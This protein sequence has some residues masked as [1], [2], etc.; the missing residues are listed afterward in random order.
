MER[1]RGDI[2]VEGISFS[3]EP[4]KPV[5]KE[6][7]FEIAEGEML[8][9]IGHSGAGKST[10]A[11]LITRLYDLEEGAIRIDGVNVKKIK[12]SDLRANIAMVSQESYLFIGTI[13]ENISYSSKDATLEEIVAAAK[14]AN[15]H[16]FIMKF[17]DG[18]DTVIGRG[19]R[20]LSG[21]EKQRVSIARAILHNPRVLILDEATSAVDTETEGLI[22]DAI[23]KL[24]KGRTTI[25][26]AHRLSTLRNADK[27]VIL[28]GGKVAEQGTHLELINKKGTYYNLVTKQAE[29]LKM[30]GV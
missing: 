1:V 18:Y 5:L 15:A 13:A 8:G 25:A 23:D 16:D 14:M 19:G 3:Y 27:L 22:Q 9:L 29:A 12:V 11:N 10:I 17:P 28:D 20:E 26:I 30:K 4:N 24:I 7:S 2:S 21:G 6:I